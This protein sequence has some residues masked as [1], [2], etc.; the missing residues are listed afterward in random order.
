VVFGK[1]AIERED[2]SAPVAVIDI[3]SNS[4][5]LVVYEGAKRSPSPLF[6][7][8]VLC[9]LGRTLA[10]TGRLD[11]DGVARALRALRRFRAICRR[12]DANGPHV[13][14]TAAAREA[15]NGAEFIARAEQDGFAADLGGGSLELI[16]IRKQKPVG[17]VT[18]PLGGLRL[19]DQSGGNLKKAAKFVETALKKVDWLSQGQGRPFYAV[20]GTWRAFARLHMAQTRYPLSVMHGYSM[21]ARKAME[22]ARLLD[23]LS[24][25][26]LE[27][28]N[29]LSRARRETVPYGALVLE[30]LLTQVQPSTFVISAFGVREGLVYKLLSGAERRRD[31]LLAACEE[32]AIQRSR[33]PEHA[34]EL[35]KWTD[36]LFRDAGERET[37][38]ERRLR[39][40]A[41]LLSD[42]GWQAHPDYR[43]E[44]SLNLIAYAAF[45]GID[46]P[47]RA[48]LALTVYFRHLG[49]INEELSP[50][51]RELV[52]DA[53]YRRARIL[54]AAFRTAAMIS[55]STSGVIL[56]T[57]IMREK[58]RLVLHLP[59]SMAD[60]DGERLDK[61]LNVLAKELGLEPEIRTGAS[62]MSGFEQ[63]PV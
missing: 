14:A 18:L 51:L 12:L 29:E 31:P 7:E 43:G 19:I 28:I 62:S 54:G 60:L 34:I 13:I 39:Q 56:R 52:D 57:P 4:V 40:A 17:G 47:G 59:D 25:S 44:Q 9:G 27:G 48:F 21:P 38:E 32:L 22:F 41:C 26:S 58:D 11:D 35:F 20:G 16:D 45:A 61:R 2:R 3:G 15:E 42:I 8:K 30:R 50:R 5:R 36:E 49:L 37:A 53:T 23:H 24:P 33:S 6:N 55:A 1:K 10:S 63:L 46:H